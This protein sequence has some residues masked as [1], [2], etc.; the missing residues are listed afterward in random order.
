VLQVL[1]LVLHSDESDIAQVH[2][3]G[4]QDVDNAVE[5]ARDAFNG[6]WGDVTSTERGRLLSRLADLVEAQAETLA[7]IESWDGG[8]I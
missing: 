4:T 6:L 8:K 1:T 7:T 2:A 3:A 5:A